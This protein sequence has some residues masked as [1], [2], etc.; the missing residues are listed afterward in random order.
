MSKNILRPSPVHLVI[1]PWISPVVL[2]GLIATIRFGAHGFQPVRSA[3]LMEILPDRLAGGGLGVV[4]T[5]V[6]GVGALAPG[7]EGLL[8][9]V[10]DL[11]VA[12]GLLAMSMTVATIGAAGLWATETPS[13]TAA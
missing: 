4:R 11:R 2:G 9:D 10:S 13:G 12:F 6:M 5:L 8:A 1:F 3:Y 7:A